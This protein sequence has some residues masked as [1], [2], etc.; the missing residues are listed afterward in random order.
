M[1][2]RMSKSLICGIDPLA[3]MRRRLDCGG[4]VPSSGDFVVGRVP[5]MIA[6]NSVVNLEIGVL[7]RSTRGEAH[8]L[9]RTGRHFAARVRARVIKRLG[10]FGEEIAKALCEHALLLNLGVNAGRSGA[11][12]RYF[13]LFSTSLN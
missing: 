9:Y 12:T 5:R 2:L 8:N 1:G 13:A 11:G 3:E 10:L 7:G 4:L 6:A